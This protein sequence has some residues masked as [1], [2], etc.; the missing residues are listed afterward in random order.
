MIGMNWTKRAPHS[1][2]RKRYTSRPWSALAACTVVSA[3]HSTPAVPQVLEAAHHLV[4]R[5]LAALVH[6]VGVVHLARPV[7]RDPD[8]EVVRL[9]ERRPL[10]VEQRAVRL[11][12]VRRPL[13]RLQVLLRQLDR[14]RGRTRAPSS[15][16]RRPAR[17]SSPPAP[18]RAPRSAAA[19]TPRADRPPSG[20]ASPDTASPSTGRSSRSSRGCTPHPSASPA[21]ETPAARPGPSGSTRVRIDAH[22]HSSRTERPASPRDR[23]RAR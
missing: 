22:A 19:R 21:D 7:D 14:P 18:A 11:D 23:R 1:S 3:F 4:E 20:T 9:E 6:A 15:S 10:L 5:A 12:R 2:R 13:P 17:R 8:Q 16:A